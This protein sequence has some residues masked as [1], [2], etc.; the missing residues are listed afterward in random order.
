MPR[1]VR[2]NPVAENTLRVENEPPEDL[3][4]RVTE[5]F[6]ERE[7]NWFDLCLTLSRVYDLSLYRTLGYSKFNEY[8]EAVCPIK[9]RTAMWAVINGQRIRQLN[10]SRETVS[11]IGFT[12][13]KEI[14]NLMTENTT[15]DEAL[16]LISRVKDLSFREVQNFVR[17]ERMVREGGEISKYVTLTFKVRD[18]AAEV[19]KAG[20]TT[21][22]EYFNTEM[23]EEALENL[24]VDWDLNRDGQKSYEFQEFFNSKTVNKV[25]K[26]QTKVT[27]RKHN[28]SGKGAK[29]K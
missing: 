17:E 12:K 2:V 8:V 26:T 4:S 14:C 25:A 22:K 29:S 7:R 20:L 16:N 23:D 10:I 3:L 18:E 9:Y 6:E 19:I 21:A 28:R 1:R 5:L 27:H 24:I 11:E 13:F 15:E